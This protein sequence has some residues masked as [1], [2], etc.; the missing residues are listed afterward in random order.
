[1][2]RKKKAAGVFRPAAL[3]CSAIKLSL[4]GCAAALPVFVSLER[5]KYKLIK[6]K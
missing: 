2:F 3:D 5:R 1:M 4:A 6:P